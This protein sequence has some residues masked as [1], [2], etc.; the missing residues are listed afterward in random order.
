MAAR[1]VDRGKM[2][3]DQLTGWEQPSWEAEKT[4]TEGRE[5]GSESL[6]GMNSWHLLPFLFAIQEINQNPRLLPNITLGYNIYENYFS[7]KMTF[8][9]MLDFL[10]PGQKDIANYIC[11]RKNNLVAVIAG[12]ESEISNQMLSM[13][14]IYKIPLMQT[15]ATSVQKISIQTRSMINVFPKSS[16]SYPTKNLWGSP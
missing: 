12:A 3:L 10:S 8:D 9:A 11:E 14:G 2:L 6:P 5:P 4:E 13:L 1:R 7:A 15:I 16:L